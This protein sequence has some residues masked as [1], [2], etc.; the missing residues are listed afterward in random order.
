MTV[1]LRATV[2]G[3]LEDWGTT[4]YKAQ[5]PFRPCNKV[6]T[7]GDGQN[8][9]CTAPFVEFDICLACVGGAT[10]TGVTDHSI[11]TAFG[12][13]PAALYCGINVFDDTHQNPGSG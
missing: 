9:A 3:A 1:S 11:A 4:L 2:D 8:D 13:T 6:D 10:W 5:T 7:D 12:W